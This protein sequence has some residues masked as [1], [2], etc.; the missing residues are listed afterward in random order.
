MLE[1]VPKEKV[2]NG[3]PFYTRLWTKN[4]DQISSKAMGISDAQ[5]W[6]GESGMELSWNEETGQYY[7][8]LE[9]EGTKIQLWME[10]T[11]SLGLKMDLI[12]QYDLAGVAAWKLGMEPAEAWDVIC[13]D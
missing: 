1:V 9:S 11:R 4:G 8:E 7:G 5:K 12:K 2:I 13:W 10:E 3:V 6:I